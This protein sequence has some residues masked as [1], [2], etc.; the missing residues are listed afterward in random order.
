MT[1]TVRAMVWRSRDLP[2]PSWNGSLQVTKGMLDNTLGWLL[3]LYLTDKGY[4]HLFDNNWLNQ[5][6]FCIGDC[7]NATLEHSLMKYPDMLVVKI[8]TEKGTYQGQGL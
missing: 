2:A 5:I 8:K 1:V 7:I 6:N 3:L 4:I